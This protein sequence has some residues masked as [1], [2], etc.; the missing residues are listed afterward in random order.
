M[1]RLSPEQMRLAQ[2]LTLPENRFCADCRAPA[3]TW[4]SFS[5][6]Y[7]VCIECSG[8][9]RR[10]GTHIT[11]IRS[12]TLDKWEPATVELMAR[13]GNVRFNAVYEA[14]LTDRSKK[15]R[16]TATMDER[17]RYIRLKY[18]RGAY[19]A[20]PTRESL[21]RAAAEYDVSEAALGA[22][23]MDGIATGGGGGEGGGEAADGE[24]EGGGGEGG[25]GGGGSAGCVTCDAGA[26]SRSRRGMCV[27]GGR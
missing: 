23:Y 7:F 25:G 13:V 1:A 21:L 6:G 5:L 9:H 11:K 26:S 4:A 16:P 22:G 18:E 12:T 20:A 3:P 10:L 19:R 14:A 2:L 17:E 15:P 24:F 27:C 8:V